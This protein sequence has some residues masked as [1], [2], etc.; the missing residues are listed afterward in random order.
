LLLLL[1][2]LLLPHP[3]VQGRVWGIRLQRLRRVAWQGRL[4]LLLR[5]LPE[6]PRLGLQC[7]LRNSRRGSGGRLRGVLPLPLLGLLLLLVQ[8]LG[9]AIVLGLNACRGIWVIC[10]ML[11]HLLLL[12]QKLLLLLQLL[13]LE[14]LLLLLLLVNE[15][16]LRHLLLHPRAWE[17]C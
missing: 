5:L 4:L 9:T 11:L 15:L 2:R 12:S 3:I 8:L 10:L 14:L 7:V 17:L 6:L 1:L 13:L 16:L